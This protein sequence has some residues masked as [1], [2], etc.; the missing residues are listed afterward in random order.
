MDYGRLD[1]YVS[2]KFSVTRQKAQLY[3][4][5]NCV[6]VNQAAVKKPSYI[7][8]EGDSVT[9]IK[10]KFDFVSRGGYKLLKAIEG[11]ELDLEGKTCI[12]IGASAGGFT[13]CMLDFGAQKV[14]AVDVGQNQLSPILLSDE[15]VV[16]IENVNVKHLD[17]FR[18]EIELADFITVDLSFISLTKTVPIIKGFLKSGGSIICLIKPQF[19]V[20]RVHIKNGVVRDKKLHKSVLGNLFEFFEQ[21]KL[22][23][24]N[25]T[26]S[27]IKGQLGN[28][29]YLVELM[30]LPPSQIVF[31]N[32]GNIIDSAFN[33]L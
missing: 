10:L 25:C 24:N 4:K 26:Y 17:M 31:F 5:E 28:I 8:K 32:L 9:L 13:H 27:P 23:V 14:F 16:N 20:G 1:V 18:G 30:K 21:Q 12:D 2:E 11:F 15:R 33:E 3:I 29:E 22:Y 7:V 19:E 6:L